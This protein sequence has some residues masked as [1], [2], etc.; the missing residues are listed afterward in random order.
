MVSIL[1]IK[2]FTVL[3]KEANSSLEL[4]NG[5]KLG[6]NN[7]TMNAI[8]RTAVL[9]IYDRL[10]M[11]FVGQHCTARSGKDE[12][13]SLTMTQAS[14]NYNLFGKHDSHNRIA[15]LMKEMVLKAINTAL[16]MKDSMFCR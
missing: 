7:L 16:Y 14:S 1:N 12:V 8:G 4:L 15:F 11:F 10:L 3:R 6:L 5:V 2:Q 13:S 9:F